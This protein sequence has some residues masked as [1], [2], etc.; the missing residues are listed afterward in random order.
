LIRKLDSCLHDVIIGDPQNLATK[1]YHTLL[2]AAFLPLYAAGH[3][4]LT[5]EWMRCNLLVYCRDWGTCLWFTTANKRI[6]GI[7]WGSVYCVQI[8]WRPQYAEWIYED[9]R[10]DGII[11]KKLKLIEIKNKSFWSKQQCWLHLH[12][13][14]K[15]INISILHVAALLTEIRYWLGL[16]P[17]WPS[18]P[19]RQLL[20]PIPKN[21][22]LLVFIQQ[23][24]SW[25]K[26]SRTL[27]AHRRPGVQSH[28]QTVLQSEGASRYLLILLFHRQINRC[29]EGWIQEDEPRDTLGIDSSDG[30]VRND[31]FPCEIWV[32]YLHDF[33]SPVSQGPGEIRGFLDRA[34]HLLD[35][36]SKSLADVTLDD[37]DKPGF[38][39]YIKR[40]PL[41]VILVIAPWKWVILFS[42][43]RK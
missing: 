39:R 3:R 22:I 40:V 30:T 6:L 43:K 29:A 42:W 8:V 36:A 10:D 31:P 5:Q 34:N 23:S 1:S 33:E 12:T 2:W 17:S 27:W 26:S 21:H 35:I 16:L 13:G 7:G 24:S 9:S 32:V 28:W 37:S 4:G 20:F 18:R 25:M 41:G 19:C 14:L 11:Q 38:R 15:Y